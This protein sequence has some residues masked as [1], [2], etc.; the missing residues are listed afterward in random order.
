MQSLMNRIR[1]LQNIKQTLEEKIEA[2]VQKEQSE[3]EKNKDISTACF[4]KMS[5]IA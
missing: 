3:V 5:G 2:E 4:E 1:E